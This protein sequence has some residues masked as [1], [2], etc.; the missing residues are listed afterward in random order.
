MLKMIRTEDQRKAKIAFVLDKI[1]RL[2]L[3]GQKVFKDKIVSDMCV[4][5]GIAPRT[6]RDYVKVLV[7]GG[8]VKEAKTED[9]VLLVA[10]KIK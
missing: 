10:G 7:D 1:K 6:A 9:G 5:D 4:K 3:R 8:F 2:Q